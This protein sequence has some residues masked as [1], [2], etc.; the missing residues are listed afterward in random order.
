MNQAVCPY[1]GKAE[2]LCEVGCEHASAHDVG[3]MVRYCSADYRQCDR[4]RLVRS[5]ENLPYLQ[6]MRRDLVSQVSH[7]VRTPLTAIRSCSE[8]LLRYDL[9]DREKGRQF[10]KVIHDE[11]ER[12]SRSM[13]DLLDGEEPSLAEQP[14]VLT[15]PMREERRQEMSQPARNKGWVVTFAGTGINLALGILYTWSIFKDAIKASIEKGGAGAFNW[16]PASLNDPYAVCCLVFTFAMIVAGRIQD[17]LSPRITALIGGVLVSLGFLW[18]SQT[19]SYT[20]WVLGFGVLAGTGIGF[21]YS[22]ATPP[23]LKWFPPRRTGLIAGLVVSGFGLASVYIAPLSKYLVNHWGLQSAMLFF[24]V[25][26]LIVVSLLSMLLVNPPKG[27]VPEGAVPAA[28][29]AKLKKAVDMTPSQ[30]IKTPGFYVL[31]LLFFIGSGAGLM[32]I[33][34]VAGMAKK[35]LGEMAFV[36][37]AIMA[38]GNAGGRILAGVLSDKIGRARTLL[39]M[40]CFQAILMFVAIPVVGAKG[41]GALPIVLLATFIGFNY[42]TNLSLF[43]SFAKDLWGLKNFGVNYGVLFSAWGV[44]GFVLGRLSEMLKAA[45]GNF[46]ACFATAGVALALGAALSLAIRDPKKA[47]QPQVAPD[48]R[49]AIQK[50]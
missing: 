30:I 20:A 47:V 14:V 23:A 29:A 15:E 2:S 13:E 19:T 9:H 4:Y 25:A 50:I 31:W 43:P 10:L 45:T 18:I 48:A 5:R 22:A 37:V 6:Q 16:H 1:F 26:F 21:G 35:S 46:D 44:G 28:A 36:A 7:T 34:S 42:G 3:L 27:Y 24:G 49:P 11:A 8:I 38:I 40:M 41:F 17:R 12:L 33:G 32:V 39:L